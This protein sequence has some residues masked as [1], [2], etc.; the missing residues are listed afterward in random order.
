MKNAVQLR[1]TIGPDHTVRLPAEIPTGEAEVIVLFPAAPGDR[2]AR[3]EARRE[4]F[5]RLAG[6]AKVGE[7]FDAPLPE[8]NGVRTLGD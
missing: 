7:D 2:K 8:E 3:A 1:V 6:V 4:M 5:G